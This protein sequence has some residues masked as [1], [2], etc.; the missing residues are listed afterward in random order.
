MYVE[1]FEYASAMQVLQDLSVCPCSHA[2]LFGG[3]QSRPG[4]PS[5][6]AIILRS[7]MGRQLMHM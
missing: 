2:P 7:R 4:L 1:E 3:R 6:T 5:A